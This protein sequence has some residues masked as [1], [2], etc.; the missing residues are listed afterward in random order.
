VDF[1]QGEKVVSIPNKGWE[2]DIMADASKMPT[3][4]TVERIL[5]ALNCRCGQ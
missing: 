3:A 2:N 4:A 5:A 1:K